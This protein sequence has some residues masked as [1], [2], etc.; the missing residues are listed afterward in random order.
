MDRDRQ[1]A[2]FRDPDGPKVLICT[3]VGGEGRNFQFAHHLVNYDL[4][5]SPA[6]MEQRIGRLDRIGQTQPVDIHVFD[7]RGTLASDVLS[8]HCPLSPA[9]EHLIGERELARMKPHAVL[10]N[11]ARGRLVDE[12][13]L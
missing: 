11:T 6:T 3:E 7:V 4:P 12:A 1:V 2:R 5:W 13:V 8:L 10:I 9:T